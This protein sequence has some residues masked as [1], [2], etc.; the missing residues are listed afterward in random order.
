TEKR[1]DVFSKIAR[2]SP[3]VFAS[4]HLR[5]RRKFC[6]LRSAV[7]S[8]SARAFGAPTQRILLSRVRHQGLPDIV[9][10]IRRREVEGQN[11]EQRFGQEHS[12]MTHT[13]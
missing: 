3:V 6:H 10:K 11:E 8:S 9:A 1:Y 12:C 2:K 5:L 13:L 7:W 4:A